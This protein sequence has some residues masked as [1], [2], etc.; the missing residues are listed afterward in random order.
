M[1]PVGVADQQMDIALVA[2]DQLFAQRA[3]AG[4]GVD[5]QTGVAGPDLNAG[6]IAAVAHAVRG[7]DGVGAA[8]APEGDLHDTVLPV[9]IEYR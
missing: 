9:Q 2:C 3:D 7:G 4:T 1:V 5:N 8:H 6:R